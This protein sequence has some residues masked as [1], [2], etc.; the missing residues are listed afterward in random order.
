MIG[1]AR[2]NGRN[3]MTGLPGVLLTDVVTVEPYRDVDSWDTATAVRCLVDETPS[4]LL[5]NTGTISDVTVRLFCPPDTDIPKGSKVT[6]ADGRL[7][8]VQAVAGRGLTSLFPVPK[9]IEAHVRLGVYAPTPIGAVT[10]TIVRRQVTGRD[11]YGNDVYGET[12]FDVAGVAVG[13]ITSQDS[14]QPGNSRVT[15]QRTVVFPPGTSVSP[16]DRLIIF[17]QRWGID[18]E[19]SVVVEPVLGLTAGIVVRAV[20]TTG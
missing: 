10:V 6:L 2:T 12:R 5:T 17:G 4:D 8:S 15:R 3:R 1:R 19:P 16:Q 11:P 7:G 20:R 14:Q 9:H 18:G 13:Q